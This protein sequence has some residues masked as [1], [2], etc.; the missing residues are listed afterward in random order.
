MILT[1]V[2]FLICVGSALHSS[3]ILISVSAF[4]EKTSV[5]GMKMKQQQL[6]CQRQLTFYYVDFDE[7]GRHIGGRNGLEGREAFSQHFQVLVSQ[8]LYLKK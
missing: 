1:S 6:F 5:N 2:N 8:S 4:I 7:K 3:R